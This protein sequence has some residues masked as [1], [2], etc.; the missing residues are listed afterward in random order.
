MT[1]AVLHVARAPLTGVW[2][3]IRNLARWQLAEGCR[4]GIGSLEPAS[5]PTAYRSDLLSLERE[6]IRVYRAPSPDIFGTGAFLWHQLNS[7]ISRWARD[8]SIES[9]KSVVVHFHEAWR[10]GALHPVRAKGVRSC[11]TYHGIASEAALRRQPV[12]R[13]IHTYWA[14]RLIRYDC[15]LVTTDRATAAAAED[16][17]GVEAWRFAFVPIGVPEPPNGLRGCPVLRKSGPDQVLTVGHIGILDQDKGWRITAQAV[18]ELRRGG[19]PIRFLIAGTGR[20]EALVREWCAARPGAAEY[21]GHIVN[22]ITAVFP[23]LDVLSMPS[24]VAGHPIAALEALSLGIPVVATATG[25]IPEAIEHNRNGLLAARTVEDFRLH[26]KTLVE[27]R[28]LHQRLS[29]GARQSYLER[30]TMDAMG[31]SY[32]EVYAGMKVDASQSSAE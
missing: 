27:D 31:R 25:G 15:R 10:A 8:F 4:V 19:L 13:A 1:L 6:G 18:D 23:L 3:F 17:F 2:S 22:P 20:D 14:H 29:D 32:A 9:G 28:N 11:T 30:F 12:R 5:W 26:L 7:P 16:L 21:L 24:L